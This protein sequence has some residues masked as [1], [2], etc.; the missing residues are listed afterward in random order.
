MFALLPGRCR[1][2]V[3]E[4]ALT[5]SKHRLSAS[6]MAH[7]FFGVVELV[8]TTQKNQADWQLLPDVLS[9]YVDVAPPLLLLRFCVSS[10]DGGGSR[11]DNKHPA[12]GR[13][14]SRRRPKPGDCRR[15]RIESATEN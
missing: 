15:R 5:K 10:G 14:T 11:G 1:F 7:E 12:T 8:L 9:F 2:A 3:F 13:L 4:K 6:V